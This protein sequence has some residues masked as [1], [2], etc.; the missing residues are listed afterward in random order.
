MAQESHLDATRG[1]ACGMS[2]IRCH[3]IQT[4]A[5]CSMPLVAEKKKMSKKLGKL[6][7]EIHVI[8]HESICIYT[9]IPRSQDD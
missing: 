8:I 3:A 2:L 7:T 9:D 5:A 6:V 4:E 1:S